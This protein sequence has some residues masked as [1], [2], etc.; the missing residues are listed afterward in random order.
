MADKN[1]GATTP[2]ADAADD[3][4][5][6]SGGE[7]LKPEE[8]ALIDKHL[9]KF[10]GGRLKQAEAQWQSK[11]EATQAKAEKEADDAAQAK[12]LKDDKKYDELITQH[13]TKIADIEPALEAANLKLTDFTTAIEGFLTKRLEELGEAAK[14][15]V[16][17]L[18]GSPD[19]LAKL[20]WLTTNEELFK[21]KE[22]TPPGT[23]PRR[24]AK[25]PAL[26]KKKEEAAVRVNF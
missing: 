13:E 1:E 22:P 15:A 7:Q 21:T 18:P 5:S 6:D 14:T 19:I 23:P 25:S 16:D 17:N 12:Q 2:A 20:N 24:G 26:D 4:K 8:Q 3:N 9:E 11:Q 10:I